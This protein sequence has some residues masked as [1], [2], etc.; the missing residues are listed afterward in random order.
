MSYDIYIFRPASADADVEQQG[1]SMFSNETVAQ[2][3]PDWPMEMKSI[4]G[5]LITLA[6]QLQV[7]GLGTQAE[8][9]DSATTI[10]IVLRSD[11]QA[12]ASISSSTDF[13]SKLAALRRYLDV[14]EAHGFRVLDPQ[15]G[16]V[17][18]LGLDLSQL[19]NTSAEEEDDDGT[20][21]FDADFLC[22]HDPIQLSCTYAQVLEHYGWTIVERTPS[23]MKATMKVARKGAQITYAIKLNKPV[24]EGNATKVGLSVWVED[25]DGQGSYACQGLCQ[26]I[27]SAILELAP[28]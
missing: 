28:A 19:L 10:Q 15:V 12:S 22:N 11:G 1:W 16:Q 23:Y 5:E 27:Q 4:I 24:S 21:K 8:L 9:T 25:G 7:G 17:L 20:R 6:P 2:A 26:Y 18:D 14:F 13:G 3:S